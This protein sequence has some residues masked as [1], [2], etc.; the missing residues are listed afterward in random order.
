MPQP[1]G[2]YLAY[3]GSRPQGPNGFDNQEASG[4]GGLKE[5]A[6]SAQAGRGA[7]GTG[8]AQGLKAAP[9]T[10]SKSAWDP[11]VQ[12]PRRAVNTPGCFS[13]NQ[14]LAWRPNHWATLPPLPSCCELKA[15]GCQDRAGWLQDPGRLSQ[16]VPLHCGHSQVAAQ[17]GG[18]QCLP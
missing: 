6:G 18:S 9:M 4:L 15:V 7:G 14:T 13:G 17:G 11:G 12:A 2:H 1:W 16:G 5:P 8:C 10:H 3:L